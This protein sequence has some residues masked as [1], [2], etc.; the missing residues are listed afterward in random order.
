MKK[1]IAIICAVVLALLFWAGAYFWPV[2]TADCVVRVSYTGFNGILH[3]PYEYYAVSGNDAVKVSE[4]VLQMAAPEAISG[5]KYKDQK[6]TQW[7]TELIYMPRVDAFESKEFLQRNNPWLPTDFGENYRVYYHRWGGAERM[8]DEAEQALMV[9]AAE[10]LHS[11]DIE[12][13]SSM[14]AALGERGL[15]WFIVASNGEQVMLQHREERLYRIRDDGSLEAVMDCPQG[16]QFDYYW[17][18]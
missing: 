1:W 2:W 15:T 11:G 17:F 8:P 16:G 18:P 12:D 14:G 13:W 6:T 9:R 7:I 4:W 5:N 10:T 3:E